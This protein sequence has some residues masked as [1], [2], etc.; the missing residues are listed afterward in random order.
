MRKYNWKKIVVSALW[1][2]AGIGAIVLLGAAIQK[3][4]QKVCTAIRIEISGAE[5][6]MFIDEKDVMDILRSTGRVEGNAVSALNLRS[7]E[8]IVERN[9]WVKNA[10]MFLD[11]NQVLQV[12]IE[13]RQPVARVFT[14]D[15]SSFYLDSG[16]LRLPLS[17]KL[18]ARVPSFTGFPTDKKILSK[19]DSLLLNDVVKLGKH[20]LA[21]SFWMAQVA[22][23]D[24][25]PQ[26]G[27]EI[28]P[29]VG[30]HI[31]VLGDANDLDKKFNHLYTFYKQ[32]WLQNGINT[33]E[34]L[35]VQY[36]NQVVA[37]K[38]GTGKARIDSARAQMLMQNLMA[39]PQPGMMDS[40]EAAAPAKPVVVKTTKDSVA[41][42]K[43]PIVAKAIVKVPA[44]TNSVVS[45]NNKA[46]KKPLTIEKKQAT[47]KTGAKDNRKQVNR[48][49]VN[50]K[51]ESRK[52]VAQQPKAILKKT[53]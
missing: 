3:K 15:G 1:V 8:Q 35:D 36:S 13:E 47:K 41:K 45:G 2:I 14:L 20:I 51:Q 46:V 10:E 5:R 43:P 50:K 40:N 16:S 17:D 31:V 19:P 6:H 38:K 24:I 48:K 53:K 11:N 44:K 26:S 12:S 52:P 27:F 30:D 23:I 7:M 39:Q 32:A 18:S 21:D 42:V 22:Q 25:T 37:V 33:Y 49:Q 29:V 9:A 28:V 34:I 4:N